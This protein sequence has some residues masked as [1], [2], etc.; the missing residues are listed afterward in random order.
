MIESD[1]TNLASLSVHTETDGLPATQR[2]AIEHTPFF[3]GRSAECD[4]RLDFDA[5]SRTHARIERT[6]YGLYTI[7]D[8]SRNGTLRNGETVT[9]KPMLLNAGDELVFGGVVIAVFHDPNSTT[10]TN[11]K[12]AGIGPILVDSTRREV[13]VNREVVAFSRLQFHILELLFRNANT[14]V[15]RNEI[16]E[17][18]W[19]NEDRET[20]TD[21]MIHVSIHRLRQR[22]KKYEADKHIATRKG[23]G[24]M[25]LTRLEDT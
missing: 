8:M 11:R 24:Y 5:I 20:I 18:V 2:I 3:I 17:Y 19:A 22:L 14:V 25:Y 15:S 21:D 23:F 6:K 1:S 16:A 10:A 4:L 13:L 7:E 12:A 9:G